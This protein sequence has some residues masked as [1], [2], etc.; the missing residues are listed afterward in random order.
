[1]NPNDIQD[2]KVGSRQVTAIYLGSNLLWPTTH[3]YTYEITGAILHYS[4]GSIID[5]GAVGSNYSGNYVYVTGTVVVYTDGVPT[6][7]ITNATLTPSVTNTTDFVVLNAHNIYGHNLG[8]TATSTVKSTYVDVTYRNSPSF[9]VGSAVQQER[10]YKTTTSS[11]VRVDSAPVIAVAEVPNT[12]YVDLVISRYNI[13]GGNRC[14]AYGGTATMSYSGG[15]DEANYSTTSW[16]EWTTYTHTYTSGSVVV[17]PAVVTATGQYTPVMVGSQWTVAD[18]IAQP[19]LPSWLTF[20]NGVLT[21]ASEGTTA[22]ANGRSA[23]LTAYNGYAS[24]TE[25]IYQQYN[26]VEVVGYAYN[27]SVDID[28]TGTIPS[29]GG[30]YSVDYVAKRTQSDTYTSGATAV[31]S[32][33]SITAEVTGTN[34]TPDTQ[35]VYGA[36]SFSIDVDPNIS[37]ILTRDITVAISAFGE[38]ASDTKQQD[39]DATSV[40]FTL[41]GAEYSQDKTTLLVY[42]SV[43]NPFMSQDFIIEA[44]MSDDSPSQPILLRTTSSTGVARFN[45][46]TDFPHTLFVPSSVNTYEVT[47]YDTRTTPYRVMDAEQYTL[48]Y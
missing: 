33:T 14:P 15:H 30:T 36:G 1:M 48:T 25:T 42:W 10:N 13:S 39:C 31:H 18:T 17:D 11:T 41:T 19:S 34:C 28:V 2:A 4:S 24:D 9:R 27:L 8:T 20:S 46:A 7:T 47:I 44:S 6:E 32:E 29:S 23:D 22:Y 43:V 12:R 45:L 5:A 26:V 3:V 40:V 16:T 38:S 35:F 21:I 37:T